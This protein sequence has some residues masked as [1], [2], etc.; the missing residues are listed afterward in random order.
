MHTS[1]NRRKERA[2]FIAGSSPT[3]ATKQ[4]ICEYHPSDGNVGQ[5]ALL[6]SHCQTVLVLQV[7]GTD[8]WCFVIRPRVTISII[9]PD[10]ALDQELLTLDVGTGLSIAD[11]KALVHAETGIAESLQQFYLNN[12]TLQPDSKTL[13]EVGVKDGD[14]LAM[15]TRQPPQQTQQQN[16]MGSQRRQQAGGQ[17]RPP[18]NDAQEIETARQSIIQNPGAMSSIRES[19]PALAAAVHDPNRFREVW[20]QMINEDEA[21]EQDRLEQMRLLN[22]DPFNIE[23][24]QKI[25]EMIRQQS[26]Q[27]NLQH[28]Y[29]HNPEGRRGLA[30]LY[31]DLS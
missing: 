18:G 21:R 25:E 6:W 23:A 9:A 31:F 12:V 2:L 8:S 22:E 17:R 13:E 10:H 27:E 20:L 24:Q 15:L 26:V 11:F 3:A 7:K 4:A 14:M 16:S 19:R 28:A 30:Q 29:E 5:A 1:L